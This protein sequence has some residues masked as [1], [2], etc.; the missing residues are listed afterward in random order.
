MPDRPIILFPTPERAARNLK[1]SGFQR[2]S[3]PEY[4]RQ[5]DRLHPAFQTLQTAFQQKNLK[6][7]QSPI[8]M[9]PDFALVF[10]IVGTVERPGMVI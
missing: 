7:Q 8:G 3:R 1:R 5:Y 4:R 6:I 2:I 9:N 10:E